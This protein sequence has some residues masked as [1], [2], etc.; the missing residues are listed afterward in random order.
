[1]THAADIHKLLD[2]APD[3]AGL[4]RGLVLRLLK[5]QEVSP[6]SLVSLVVSL[7]ATTRLSWLQ[8]PD[9]VWVDDY[10]KTLKARATGE[11]SCVFTDLA[12]AK[13]HELSGL[14]Y[15]MTTISK[16]LV[17]AT[18]ANKARLME[19][20]NPP[21]A[22]P[23]AYGAWL[24]TNLHALWAGKFTVAQI[25]K[26]GLYRFS[27]D[28]IAEVKLFQR[29][30]PSVGKDVVYPS[31]NWTSAVRIGHFVRRH[32]YK[33]FDFDDIKSEN[34]MWPADLVN[35]EHE[36]ISAFDRLYDEK[37]S[38]FDS[39]RE[40]KGVAVYMLEAPWSG[41][42]AVTQFYP[43]GDGA[44]T[45]KRAQMERFDEVLKLG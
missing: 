44:V 25:Q 36:M 21:Q 8:P 33:H 39:T 13:A 23:N 18:E 1:M 26:M 16:A 10:W 28:L 45:Y 4:A 30:K 3:G 24:A 2:P 22:S 35:S 20:L 15:A 5:E 17:V 38:R 34:S 31:H 43:T 42:T 29:A 6:P 32:T 19:C 27:P 11:L 40:V 37:K 7:P 41:K 9:G 12:P 14:G